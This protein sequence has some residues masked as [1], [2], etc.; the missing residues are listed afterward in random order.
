MLISIDWL[1]LH[2]RGDIRRE[3]KYTFKK[4][5]YSTQAFSTVEDI[6][7]DDNYFASMVSEPRSQVINPKTVILKVINKNLYSPFMFSQLEDLLKSLNLSYQGITRLDVCADFNYFKNGL[8]PE[9]LIN[10]FMC[11]KFRKVGQT[12]GKCHFEQKTRMH[13]ETLAFGTGKSLIRCYLYNKTKELNEVKM[14]PYIVDSWKASGLD[15]KKDVWRLEFSIKGNSLNLIDNRTGELQKVD[16]KNLQSREFLNNLYYS[17]QNQYFRFKR[18][19]GDKNVSRMPDIQLLP[20]N[21]ANWK[22]LFLTEAG[23][24]TRADKIF[25]KKLD[26]MNDE[27]RNYANYREE[28][29]TELISEVCTT[30]GLTDYYL[31]KVQGKATNTLL[32]LKEQQETMYEE[33][34]RKSEKETKDIH[35]FTEEERKE[36]IKKIV[37]NTKKTA[38]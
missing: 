34:K 18:D 2:L 21:P 3:A 24:V 26:R 8:H 17:L 33:L 12:K 35:L 9:T 38:M 22:R 30:K 37:L 4:L 28:F 7:I 13:Y 31:K 32:Y 15:T 36:R 19:T 1:Q 6:Y 11:L 5:D 25:I 14:K 29:M 10:N 23:D 20:D 16:L 27:I